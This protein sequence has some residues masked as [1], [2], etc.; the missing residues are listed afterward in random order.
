M[1]YLQFHHY[2][3]AAKLDNI[4]TDAKTSQFDFV[5]YNFN[6]VTAK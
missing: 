1:H 2:G 4:L 5:S 3:G 6:F